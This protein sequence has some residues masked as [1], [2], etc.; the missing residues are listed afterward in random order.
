MHDKPVIRPASIVMTR[1][2]AGLNVGCG[3]MKRRKM[4][5]SVISGYREQIGRYKKDFLYKAQV[6][7]VL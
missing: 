1:N 4:M 6:A 7:L 3:K 5:Q 2:T